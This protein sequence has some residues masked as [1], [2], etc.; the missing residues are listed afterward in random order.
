M[1]RAPGS[2]FRNRRRADVQCIAQLSSTP[3]LLKVIFMFPNIHHLAYSGCD[4]CVWD[5]YANPR[6]LGIVGVSADQQGDIRA[7]PV[8]KSGARAENH[9][10][11]LTKVGLNIK[12]GLI[13]SLFE[14]IN[15]KNVHVKPRYC[16][17]VFQ[18]FFLKHAKSQYLL[19]RAHGF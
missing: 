7:G 17:C 3:G 6:N 15:C 1:R 4:V 13:L 5:P 12:I 10:C 19:T 11:A 9:T 14:M 18:P 2:G 8:L 16:W